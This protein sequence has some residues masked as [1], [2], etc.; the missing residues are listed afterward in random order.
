MSY[1]DG[2]YLDVYEAYGFFDPTATT[3]TAEVVVAEEAWEGAEGAE[4]AEGWRSEL[5]AAAR[6]V[7]CDGAHGAWWVPDHRME[8]SPLM[9]AVR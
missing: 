2:D 1:T 3:H 8:A 9:A 6:A 7:G 5:L 4:G